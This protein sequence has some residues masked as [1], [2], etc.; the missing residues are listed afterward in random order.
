MT[1][2]DAQAATNW[3][4]DGEV[5]ISSE[6]ICR[7]FLGRKQGRKHDGMPSDCDD[8]ARCR[9]FLQC[10]SAKGQKAALAAVAKSYADWRPLV[11]DWAS[12]CESMDAECPSWRKGGSRWGEKTHRLIGV[13]TVEGLRLR[14]P[15]AHITTRSDGTLSSM[16][17]HRGPSIATLRAGDLEGI[18]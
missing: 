3:F 7:A 15:K 6:T 18:A 8:L 9:L 5:G 17:N 14:Y 2:K 13:L 16:F 11:R 10:L 1:A 12:V 4:F